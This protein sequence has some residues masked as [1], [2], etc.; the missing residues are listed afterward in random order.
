MPAHI[1][2]H[3][4]AATVHK[5]AKPKGK[6]G[7]DEE[8]DA[9]PPAKEPDPHELLAK[10]REEAE[11]SG[12]HG[13]EEM[14][15]EYGGQL[16]PEWV[17]DPELLKKAEDLVDPD[18][19]GAEEYEDP[20]RVVAYLYKALGG[21]F[22]AH[23]E[24]DG[25]EGE[26]APEEEAAEH[27]AEE[28]PEAPGEGEDEPHAEV[29]VEKAAEAAEAK[30]NPQ[31]AELVD[32]Y[33]PEVQGNPPAWVASEATWEEAKKAVEPTWDNYDDPW[34]VVAHVY[35]QMGGSFK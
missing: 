23:E 16:S 6:R 22:P 20:H 5:H 19:D 2:V 26:V 24:P 25:D 27:E 29:D 4:L 18:G 21:K 14:L 3:H 34:A 10:A 13:L 9:P 7:H 32:G 15:A 8:E 31:I 28:E 1:P 12:D 33:D 11:A 17:S 30:A 35:E